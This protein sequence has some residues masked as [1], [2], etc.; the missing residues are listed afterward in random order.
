[1]KY[2]KHLVAISIA[3]LVVVGCR[4]AYVNPNYS[5]DKRETPKLAIAPVLS[6]EEP[7]ASF[8]DS[9]FVTIFEDT[10]KPDL[11]VHPAYIRS[12][13]EKDKAIAGILSVMHGTDFTK[14]EL[15]NG[16]TILR[17]TNVDE[18]SRMRNSLGDADLL[19]I[20]RGWSVTSM[21]GHTFGKCTFR[22]YD[23]RSGQLIYEKAND[24]NVDMS[25][26]VAQRLI[27]GHLIGFVYDYYKNWIE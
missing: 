2:K 20:P 24:L 16:A 4:G 26:I 1:M 5:F 11:L 17:K 14:E 7:L 12:V 9:F 13:M 15:K 25:G 19:L 23:M 22:L 18:L 21:A 27:S 10:T 3:L 8:V 6:Q